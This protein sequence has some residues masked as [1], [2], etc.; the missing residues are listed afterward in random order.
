[1]WALS[2]TG[3]FQS[4]TNLGLP[5]GLKGAVARGINNKGAVVGYGFVNPGPPFSAWIRS[6]ADV[7]SVINSSG[8]SAAIAEA[9]ND[10]GIVTGTST[11]TDGSVRAF[12]W[13]VTLFEITGMLALQPL[14]GGVSSDGEAINLAGTVVGYSVAPNGV[15]TAVKWDPGSAVATDLGVGPNSEAREINAAGYILIR[16][17]STAG[18]GEVGIR[19]PSGTLSILPSVTTAGSYE[20]WGLN[21]CGDVVGSGPMSA[22]Q[23][24]ASLIVRWKAAPCLP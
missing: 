23:P 20:A 5:P 19:H 9:I 8:V 18:F 17:R 4:L 14:A 13:P 3:A 24:N 22:S 7:M 16:R 11:R 15:R 21:S 10:L 1:M 6:A 12:R 2:S